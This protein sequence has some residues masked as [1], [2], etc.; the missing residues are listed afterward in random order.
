MMN[1]IMTD[2]ELKDMELETIN[3]GQEQD[4][5]FH[6]IPKYLPGVRI[7][8]YF[9]TTKNYAYGLVLKIVEYGGR[10]GWL[11]EVEWDMKDHKY[12]SHPYLDIHKNISIVK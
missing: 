6:I 8:E 10:N 12:I 3:G 1:T 5:F 7:A 9:P 4:N 2:K 11:Y